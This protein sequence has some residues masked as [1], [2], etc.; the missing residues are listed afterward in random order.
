MLSL[1]LTQLAA[2]PPTVYLDARFEPLA[3]LVYQ[4]DM[5]SGYLP[6]S[7]SEVISSL[8]KER[9]ATNSDDA[10]FLDQWKQTM[11]KLEAKGQGEYNPRLLYSVAT[12]QSE[13][14]RTREI[15]LTSSSLLE[16]SKRVAREVE[17]QAAKELS[18][19]IARFQPAFLSWWNQEAEPKGIDFRV[20]AEKLLKSEKL[21]GLTKDLVRFYQPDLPDG[22]IVPVQFMYKPKARESSH[23]EQVGTAAVME[24]FE[25]DSPANRIDVTMHEL[26]HFFFR[27]AGVAKHE[28]LTARFQK[29]KDQSAM[30]VFA[31]MNE[32]LAT[33]LNNGMVAE[34]LMD[35]KS[36]KEYRDASLSWYFND[37]ID[38]TAKTSYD[39][40]TAY[41]K[42][43]GTLHDPA[44]AKTYVE[45]IRAGMG[46]KVDAPSVQLFGVNYVWDEQWPK[47]MGFMPRE[48]IQSTISSRYSATKV[49]EALRMA[50]ADSPMYSTLLVLRPNQI[51]QVSKQQ[52]LLAKHADELRAKAAKDGSAL[53]GTRRSTG[54][55][56]Y[57]VVAN[58]IPG[59]QKELKRLAAL[60][61]D[62]A[63][64]LP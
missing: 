12:I 59:V 62:L 48:F 7:K 44:F 28:A 34:A 61:Q 33:A 5:V 13:A 42:Q 14:E 50:L 10:K 19:V 40:L 20:K 64:I 24:F 60:K 9:I 58:D 25:G 1:L 22:Y 6:Y 26:S 47:E 32:A 39:W 36:F 2:N 56:I 17:P 3:N 31:I 8:W 46:P 4:L 23:G 54:L 57:V 38:T 49:E 27:K 18:S 15:G 29:V 63:G 30:A 43:G 53:M 37:S 41:A 21:K 45:T 11:R 16:F 52:P 55:A 51:A 35:P